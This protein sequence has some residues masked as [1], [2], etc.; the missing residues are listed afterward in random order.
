MGPELGPTWALAG[1]AIDSSR[2]WNR[3]HKACCCWYPDRVE[4]NR[5]NSES[6]SRRLAAIMALDIVG[7]SRMMGEDEDGTL[8]RLKGLRATIID[9][10]VV[11]RSGRVIKSTG[12]GILAEFGS[13]RGAIAAAMAIQ[14]GLKGESATGA[15]NRRM[16]ARIG[17]N[18]S[19]VIFDEGDVF[20]DGVNIAARLE[21]LAPTGGICVSG[22]AIEELRNLGI[23]FEDKGEVVLKN[24]A[25]PVRVLSLA[26]DGIVPQHAAPAAKL[27]SQTRLPSNPRR[28]STRPPRS[29]ILAAMVL[30]GIASV[31]AI[32][33]YL[34]PW[35]GGAD[36]RTFVTARLADVPCSWLK[37]ADIEDTPT[38]AVLVL[39]GAANA[40]DAI[41]LALQEA[42]RKAGRQIREVDTSQVAP[43]TSQ[44]CAPLE[45]FRK[46]RSNG[47]QR[48][49]IPE[50]VKGESRKS[51]D[52]PERFNFVIEPPS[53]ASLRQV[54]KIGFDGSI[55]PLGQQFR[56]L[57]T[58]SSVTNSVDVTGTGW[59]GLV[60]V[61]ASSPVNES[62][63]RAANGKPRPGYIDDLDK[64]AADGHWSI[65]MNWLNA[66][67]SSRLQLTGA[68]NSDRVRL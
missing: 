61:S 42:A 22:R 18:V 39:S 29:A 54:F 59:S 65:E 53:V 1:I 12:D 26:L 13:V 43:I 5:P 47:V 16:D 49:L 6:Q 2:S 60:L 51:N 40:S 46:Y 38:G 48:L 31:A 68:V 56:S 23:A 14:E 15:T 10:A 24:I 25:L 62:L 8:A 66:K 37:L 17:I 57:P 30:A 28:V 20:G 11:S 9:P 41:A 63:I 50:P 34:Q 33:W 58:S 32:A 44:L 55:A 21:S 36:T 64:A 7:Y 19:D 35:S 45:L 52:L 27:P 67:S 3:W 4:G